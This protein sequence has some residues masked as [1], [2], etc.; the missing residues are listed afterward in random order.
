MATDCVPV[1]T[2][3]LFCCDLVVLRCEGIVFPTVSNCELECQ[4]FNAPVFE[5]QPA[6]YVAV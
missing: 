5:L 4:R 3:R 6:V 2:L 1:D